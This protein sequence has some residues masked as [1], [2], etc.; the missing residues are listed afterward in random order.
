MQIPFNQ[1]TLKNRDFEVILTG[2]QLASRKANEAGNLIFTG[3]THGQGSKIT[4][5]CWISI[6]TDTTHVSVNQLTSFDSAQ[7][8]LEYMA[9]A[10]ATPTVLEFNVLVPNTSS[11]FA[12]ALD[13]QFRYYVCRLKATT[14]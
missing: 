14:A 8:T 13:F 7:G 4:F 2:T 12:T 3:P 6:T 10:S 5:F 11:L 9:Y 1:E